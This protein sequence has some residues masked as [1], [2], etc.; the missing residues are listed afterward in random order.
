MTESPGSVKAPRQQCMPLWLMKCMGVGSGKEERGRSEVTGDLDSLVL[1]QAQSQM[2]HVIRTSRQPSWFYREALS[3]KVTQS[4]AHGGAILLLYLWLQQAQLTLVLLNHRTFSHA[5]LSSVLSG[6]H[7]TV[8]V[9]LG[10]L[11]KCHGSQEP[12]QCPGC[13]RS[14]GDKQWRGAK[15]SEGLW[16]HRWEEARKSG[17]RGRQEAAGRQGPSS[18]NHIRGHSRAL[19]RAPGLS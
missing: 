9:Y 16:W 14:K 18:S 1:H 19:P 7:A 11:L 10:T 8:Q 4:G 12:H 3:D 13:A 2:L 17:G 6:Y 5:P 15:G